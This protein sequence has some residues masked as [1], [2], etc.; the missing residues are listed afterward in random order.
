MEP[1]EDKHCITLNNGMKLP[2]VGIGT[3]LMSD[4]KKDKEALKSAV[5]DAGYRH[6]DTASFY[7]NEQFIGEAVQELI[8]DGVVKR[9]ELVIT[10]KVWPA[11]FENVEAALRSSLEKLQVE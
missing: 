5:R 11:D 3:W 4:P 7:E 1:S 8:K 9:E 2:I 6:I 10:T